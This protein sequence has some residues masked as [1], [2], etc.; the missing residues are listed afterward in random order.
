MFHATC[1]ATANKIK[2]VPQALRIKLKVEDVL[3]ILGLSWAWWGSLLVLV[4]QRAV[5]V[6][7]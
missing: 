5:S 2:A 6:G 7:T 3:S 1:F 4:T